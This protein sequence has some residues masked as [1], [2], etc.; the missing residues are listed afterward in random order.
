MKITWPGH[1]CF[2]LESQGYQIVLD[3]YQDGSV[4]GLTTVSIEADQVLCSHGHGDHCGTEYESL[5][6]G[7]TSPFTMEI[8]NTWHDGR[9]G[10]KR[11]SNIIHIVDDIQ[12]HIARLGDL[13]CNLTPEQIDK[14]HSLT[15]LLIPVG[16]FFVINTARAPH[17]VSSHPYCCPGLCCRTCVVCKY[18]LSRRIHCRTGH[19]LG[20]HSFRIRTEGWHYYICPR[21]TFY[22][23]S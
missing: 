5:R 20:Q 13:G 3:P 4:P 9:N 7:V 21:E 19:G 14:L 11:G 12:Y 8:I 6:R 22:M 2:T 23:I 10:A 15:A 18:L 16:D 1:S 17:C